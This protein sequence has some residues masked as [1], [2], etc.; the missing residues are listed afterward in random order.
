MTPRIGAFTRVRKRLVLIASDSM[1]DS[2]PSLRL[3]LG[4]LLLASLMTACGGAAKREQERGFFLP[5]G[6]AKAG[7]AVFVALSCHRCH[8]VE[9]V[10]LPDHDLPA[11]PAIHLGGA[12]LRVKSYGELVTSIVHPDHQ[13]SP[14]YLEKLSA[15][16]K[17]SGNLSSPM[18]SY[19]DKMTVRQLV[20]L[21][22]FLHGRYRLIQPTRDEYFYMMPM[23]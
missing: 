12:I 17:D 10:T 14:Q 6:D 13:L 8:T 19:H 9:G 18:L 15:E 7:E 3:L 2:L 11:S 5:E 16:E 20:D 21:V 4:A 23:P 1:K 22:S